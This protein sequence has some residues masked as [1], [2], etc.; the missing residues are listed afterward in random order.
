VRELT[1]GSMGTA[2]D[3]GTQQ[4]NANGKGGN[5]G[6]GNGNGKGNGM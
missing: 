3:F 1:L 5:N 2:A 4:S 6:N